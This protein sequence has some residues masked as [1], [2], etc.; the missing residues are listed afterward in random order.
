MT[1]QRPKAHPRLRALFVGASLCLLMCRPAQAQDP[2]GAAY[3]V[4]SGS[5]VGGATTVP[6]PVPVVPGTLYGTTSEPGSS[7]S[8]GS[9]S[10]TAT[11]SSSTNSSSTTSKFGA[12]G[13]SRAKSSAASPDW[14][15]W[16]ANNSESWIR[17][18]AHIRDISLRRTD[19]AGT[20]SLRGFDP[21][22]P[23]RARREILP[24]LQQA[25]RS[26]EPAL[27]A[28]AAVACGRIGGPGDDALRQS[29]TTL[30]GDPLL[31]VQAS[32]LLGLGFQR[33]EDSIALLAAIATDSGL[34]R[35]LLRQPDGVPTQLRSVA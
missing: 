23:S 32:T 13:R 3:G 14:R 34:G 30:L 2:F 33:H 15:H 22:G 5:Y 21:I 17:T 19:S 24:L 8:A 11:P 6:V 9:A 27:R 16:W 28:A 1:N 12:G 20:E 26:D 18:R 25:L 10:G 31:D 35:Q 4:A 7:A 29:M